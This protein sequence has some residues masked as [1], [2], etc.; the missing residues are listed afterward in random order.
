[1][2]LSNRVT[3]IAQMCE[4]WLCASVWKQ[5][6]HWFDDVICI[7]VHT[8]HNLFDIWS[9]TSSMCSVSSASETA[10]YQEECEHRQRP[11]GGWNE[12]LHRLAP[13]WTCALNEITG[14]YTAAVKSLWQ[15]RWMCIIIVPA[16]SS[17]AAVW[18]SAQTVTGEINS[19]VSAGQA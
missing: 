8:W 13:T 18:R 1:M 17:L 16:P 6:S 4:Y 19:S 7:L 14:K 11:G 3:L 12:I 9:Q 2:K 5:N 10:P 15:S